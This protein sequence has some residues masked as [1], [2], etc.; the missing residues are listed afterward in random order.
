MEYKFKNYVKPDILENHLNL[1]GRDNDGNELSLN[2]LY[3]TRN[4]RP[5]IGIMGEFH[6]S[7][8]PRQYWKK[9]LVQ[10]KAGGIQIVS[11]YIIWIYHEPEEGHLDFTEDNDLRAFVELAG[12]L[13][14]QV[15]IRIGP[16]CHGE[17]RNGGFPDW[18]LKKNCKLRSNDEA[19][20][21]IVNGWYSAISEQLQGLYFKDGGPVIMCQVENELTDDADHLLALKNIA[22]DVG[23]E[24]PYYTVTGWNATNGAH[25]PVDDVIPVFGGYCDAPWDEGTDLL[26]PCPRYSFTGIRN[27]SAIGKDQIDQ[28]S[29]DG[30]QLPYDRY[31]YATCEIGGGLM[32]TYHRRYIIRGMD[33]YAMALIMLCEGTN[34]LGYYMYHGG[35]NKVYKDYTLQESKET[36][37]PNDY[38]IIS[39]DFQAPISSYGETRESYDLLNILHVFIKEYEEKLA[40]MTYVSSEYTSPFDDMETLRYGMRTDG[41]SGFVFI[42][43]YQRLHQ[44]EDLYDVVIDTGIVKFPP[45][46]VKGDISF[47]MPFNMDMG[48]DVI[49][50]YATAQPLCRTGNNWLFVEIP[51]I[52]P[53]YVF[54]DESNKVN[55][56]TLNMDEAKRLRKVDGNVY[57]EE[58][59]SMSAL[60]LLNDKGEDYELQLLDM[61]PFEIPHIYAQELNYSNKQVY[62]Y[63]LICHHIE[64][65]VN[66]RLKCDVMQLY[67]K[68]KLVDD[69]FF[70]NMPWRIPCKLIHGNDVYIIASEYQDDSYME[71]LPGTTSFS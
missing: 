35:S 27:D 25:I 42:N 68:G 71:E 14:L 17:V 70:H 69:E 34:L 53:Q 16:W 55:I 51:G 20:L 64:G 36:G 21:N 48:D 41:E 54:E 50:K 39:Y 66:I 22:M 3:F 23:I 59:P 33:V 58:K 37:Y 9:E 61:E 28:V 5:F 1:G 57:F 45:I 15:C 63:K 56:I 8:V 2:S 52:E 11:T 24:V 30:W 26:P 12:E 7:R 46:D 4:N 62:C 6:F 65:F 29:D 67:V 18:L 40:P 31:P 32:N 44:M 49:L 10:M 60:D 43:H 47:F 19:Y 38:P 13:G